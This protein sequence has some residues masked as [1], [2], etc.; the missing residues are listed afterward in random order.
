MC[1]STCYNMACLYMCSPL[2]Y[3]IYNSTYCHRCI[4]RYDNLCYCRAICCIVFGCLYDVAYCVNALQSGVAILRQF[5]IYILIAWHIVL[6]CLFMY[7]ISAFT[8]YLPAIYTPMWLLSDF[9]VH[10]NKL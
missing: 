2:R 1:I 6:I 3:C 4:Y 10:V 9:S 8:Q 7:A 5:N